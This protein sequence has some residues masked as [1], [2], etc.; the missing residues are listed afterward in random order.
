MKQCCGL[1]DKKPRPVYTMKGCWN[2]SPAALDDAICGSHYNRGK[3]LLKPH[4]DGVKA[5][6]KGDATPPFSVRL[7]LS[8]S[9]RLYCCYWDAPFHNL[10]LSSFLAPLFYISVDHDS[11]FSNT[12][13]IIP[14]L[15]I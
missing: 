8:F 6:L 2:L 13:Q 7:A 4:L 12:F 9:S 14:V 10:S 1:L 3:T 15:H 5:S 11:A